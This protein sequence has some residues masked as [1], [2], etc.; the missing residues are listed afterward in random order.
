KPVADK[1]VADKP[2]A[3]K[4]VADKPVADKP[5]PKPPTAKPD[6][7]AYNKP[8]E[9]PDL[10]PV[11]GKI[12][13]FDFWATWCEPCKKLDPALVELAKKYPSLV[14]VRKLDVV[15]W[16]SKAAER[17]L[18]PG[19]FDLPHLKIYDTSGKRVLEKSSA[20]GKLEELIDQT[21]ALVEAE[22]KKRPAAAPKAT[23]VDIKADANG[24][25]PSRIAV[26]RGTPVTL[27]FTRT[28]DKTCATEVVLVVD[29]KRIEKPLPL[30]KRV[31]ITL[32]FAKSGSIPFACA[33]DMHRGTIDVR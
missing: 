33:M 8:G 31:E 13:I 11:K 28:S 7:A 17:Y 24:F 32:T 15:D 19:G 30:G 27:A 6:V 20:V 26:T 16:D 10:V 3:D 5:A 4:P 1:P 22:A 25:A 18:T 23:R 2:V 12:T 14:A 29:G 21:K 9:A